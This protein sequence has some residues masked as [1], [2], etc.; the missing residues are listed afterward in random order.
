MIREPPGSATALKILRKAHL[1]VRR[2][3]GKPRSYMPFLLQTSDFI[4]QF[5][6]HYFWFL[7]FNSR[8][9]FH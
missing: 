2:Y 1:N 7:S 5:W 6:I 8:A 3:F 9:Y 4:V